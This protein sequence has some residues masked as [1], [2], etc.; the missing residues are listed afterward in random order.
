MAFVLAGAMV[1]THLV[2]PFNKLRTAPVR[3]QK[4]Q[5]KAFFV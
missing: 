2:R 5:C 3:F 4:A 1:V